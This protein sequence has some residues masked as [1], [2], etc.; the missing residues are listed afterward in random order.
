MNKAHEVQILAFR[1]PFLRLR[2]DGKDYDVN[3]AD[4]S[5]RL[6]KAAPE[7]RK[8][9]EVSPS[10]YGLH[11]PEIDEDLSIDRL[12]GVEHRPPFARTRA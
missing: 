2:V 7:Q 9:V 5:S 10:G 6:A 3:L 8:R 11:W 4:Q 1:D 12:I